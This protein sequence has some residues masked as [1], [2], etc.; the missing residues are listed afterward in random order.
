MNL[1]KDYLQKLA[2]LAGRNGMD[3]VLICPSEEMLFFTGFNP[4]MCERFQ[5]LFVKN[6]GSLFYICNL[7]YAGQIREAFGDEIP[8]YTWFDGDVMTD[9]VGGILR[10]QGLGGRTIGVNSSAQA[11]NILEIMDKTDVT[12]RNAKPLLEEVRIHKSHEE[13][14]KLRKAASIDDEVYVEVLKYI[15]AGMTE[16]DVCDFL[17]REMA[18]RGGTDMW[19]I[20]ASGPNSSYP[21]YND[22]RRVL[23]DGDAVVLDFGCKWQGMF[24]DMSRTVF[25]GRIS[26]ENRRIYELVDRA[27][28]AAE[29]AVKEGAFIPDIDQAARDVLATQGL[30]E[31]L[32]N[33]VGHGIGYMVHEAPDIKKSNPRRLEK[34]MAFSIEPGAYLEGRV[35]MRVEDIV[36]INEKGEREVL[37][38]SSRAIYEL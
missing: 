17:T 28:H 24:S 35:G 31:T 27:N 22:S 19:N 11:F 1:R 14:E 34:G 23:Q 13:L 4:M 25:I 20:V 32:I 37:N 2:E 18:A 16:Q 15:K 12:F 10:E 5:G 38:K 26:D 6:D 33:R 3:A 8:V 7:L 36:V 30:A 21:H 29:D 9:I